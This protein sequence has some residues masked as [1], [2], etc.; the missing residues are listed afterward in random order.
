MNALDHEVPAPAAPPSSTVAKATA[1][2][3]PGLRLAAWVA[4][5]SLAGGIALRILYGVQTWRIDWATFPMF[6]GDEGAHGLMAMHILRGARP[7][8][9]YGAFYHGAFDAYLTAVLFKV[10]GASLAIL[11]VT[12]ALF[13]LA[14]IAATYLVGARLY[15][16]RE[17][18]LAAALVAL[19]S[20]FF[21]EWGTLSLC[22]YCGYATMVVAVAALVLGA[23]ERVT[24]SRLLLL[25]LISGISIWSNQL[26]VAFVGV[27]LAALWWWVPMSRRNWTVLALAFFIGLAPLIWGNIQTPFSTFRQLGRKALFAW[28]LS[29]QEAKKA[30]AEK[31]IDDD[32]EAE[33]AHEYHALPLL[34]VLG[35]QPGRDGVFSAGGGFGALVLG[36]GLLGAAAQAFAARGRD[37]TSAR[38]HL[39][40]FALIGVGLVMGIGGFRGQPIGRYQLPLYPLFAVLAA[41]WLVRLSPRAAAVVVAAV[42]VFHAVDISRPAV[43]DE[44][45]SAAAAIDALEA[46]GLHHGFAASP[47][48][49]VIFR[50]G[51]RVVLVPLDHSRYL[52]YEKQVDGAGDTFYLYRSYQ[53]R[54]PAHRALLRYLEE[55]GVAHQT[56]AVGDYHIL[57]DFQ[58]PAALSLAALAEIRSDFR[59]EKF[60]Q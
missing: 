5:L 45:T 40:L 24:T 30:E 23:F 22:G 1:P 11:R 60:G 58:P 44:T 37:A 7:V 31:A 49:D 41:G 3:E 21:F 17:G 4:L 18:L 34:E 48:Y 36:L 55:K 19:P 57:Y 9:Y 59:K 32:D 53:E 50:S 46:K 56:A 25:G 42:A 15:G 38:G 39:L 28:T 6:L 12:P 52:P 33:D 2:S 26:S 8:F 14:T 16:R 54:K 10:F 35:A 47:M 29:K 27:G 43:T 20:K 51:E 13:A